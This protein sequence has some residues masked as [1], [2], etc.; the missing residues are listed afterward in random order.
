[1]VAVFIP[2]EIR[3]I[4]S[5]SLNISPKIGPCLSQRPFLC[6]Y[7]QLQ[8]KVQSYI[9]GGHFAFGADPAIVPIPD[10]MAIFCFTFPSLVWLLLS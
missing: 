7:R 5:N 8:C 6:L 3:E 2:K 4:F 9:G 1:M 10:H